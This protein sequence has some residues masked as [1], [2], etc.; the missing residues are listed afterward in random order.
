MKVLLL[1]KSGRPG[2]GDYFARMMP[3]GLGWI[4]ATLRAH[5]VDSSLANLSRVSWAEAARLLRR[6]RPGVAGIT[7]YTFNRHAGLRLAALA[8]KANP[9]CVVI[10]GG[11]HATHLGASILRHHPEVDAVALG[12]G[13]LTML[14][15]VRAAE[16]GQP[17]SGVAGLMVRGAGGTPRPTPPRPT[18]AD[19]DSLPFPAAHYAG[20]H[21]DVE[22]ESSFVITS[23][24]CPARCTFCNTPDFWG[25]RMRFRSARHMVEEIRYL[26]ETLGLLFVNVRDDTFTVN[27]RRV[28]EFCRQLIDAGLH[29]RW[30]C[31]SRVNAIDE[32]RLAWMR[33]AGCDHIQYGIE[34]GSPALLARLAK[35]ISVEEIRQAAAAT[36]RVGLTLSIYLISGIPEE[37]EEDVRL[38]QEL[39]EEIR[40]HDGIVA[41]LAV[42]PGT[43][44]YE[45]MKRAG[46]IADD[47]WIAEPR[48]TL[49]AMGG[50]KAKRSFRR[51]TRMCG[52]I[53]RAARYTRA[54][55][56]EHKR[57]LPGAWPAW[58]ASAEAYEEEGRAGPALRE[59]EAVLELHPGHPWALMGT[60]RV[61][62]AT[63][64]QEGA[65][66]CLDQAAASVPGS[67][68]IASMREA[69][70]PVPGRGPGRRARRAVTVGP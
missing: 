67:S 27:K 33:R 37:T 63:G 30:S 28:I 46:R 41:P 3:V 58:L 5:G 21:L 50:E 47:D 23:R 43:H 18:V 62:A 20:H 51:L 59:Y 53:G 2:A 44:L 10:V 8:R 6:E 66:L 38:T 11:P 35:D 32:E 39:L 70:G 69:L 64:D 52:R 26:K 68:L 31:Q 4:H 61:L 49:Y 40:P 54:E 29:V 57:R 16:A 34:S 1:Y 22:A 55:L 48:D 19:L 9:R 42:F 12:E 56:E 13:E 25:T 24:G 15:A 14:D 17:L 7:L 65:R 60:A 36:R 45:E